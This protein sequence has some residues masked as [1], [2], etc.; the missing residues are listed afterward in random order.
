PRVAEVAGGALADL[1]EAAEVRV[2]VAG[3]AALA[4]RAPVRRQGGGHAGLLVGAREGEAG[5][6][7]G[8]AVDGGPL[9]LGA[10]AADAALLPEERLA[11]DVLVAGRAVGG[12]AR[13]AEQGL[14]VAGGAGHADVLGLEGE[15]RVLLVVEVQRVE[16]APALGV[17]AA[18]AVVE[19]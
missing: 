19:R 14:G 11:V 3:V 10:V 5:L 17:V 9:D 18:L 13:Q 8:G 15:A 1:A 16:R 7:G 12:P 4:R 6:A 2:L